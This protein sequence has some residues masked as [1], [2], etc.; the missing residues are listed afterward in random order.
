M[1]AVVDVI[2][3]RRYV[4]EW[5]DDPDERSPDPYEAKELIRLSQ[6]GENDE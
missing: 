3:S 4:V 2:V 1:G 5:E 6:A